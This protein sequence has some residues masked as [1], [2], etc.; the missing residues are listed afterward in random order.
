[1]AQGCVAAKLK[2]S[3]PTEHLC[4]LQMYEGLT[5][6]TQVTQPGHK[7]LLVQ[8]VTLHRGPWVAQSVERPTS[9]WVMVSQFVGSGPTSDSVLTV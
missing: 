9:A 7:L 1:M 5:C 4:S 2:A 8:K 6:H 3:E